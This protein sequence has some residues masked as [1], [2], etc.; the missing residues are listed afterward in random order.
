MLNKRSTKR[1]PTSDRATLQPVERTPSSSPSPLDLALSNAPLPL[2][3]LPGFTLFP[4]T[5]VP[6]HVFEPRYRKLVADLLSGNQLLALPQLKP[7]YE[8]TYYGRPELFPICGAAR[9]VEHAELADGRY[10]ILVQ[11]VARVRLVEE[12]SSSSLY[13]VARVVS[14]P[15]QSTASPLVVNAL[16]DELQSLCSR[17]ERDLPAFA[18]IQ[19]IFREGP[20]PGAIADRVGSALIADPSER[21]ILLDQLDPAARLE[22]LIAHLHDLFNAL[23]RGKPERELN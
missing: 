22:R 14:L 17:L 19:S 21:Q 4:G 6:L 12:V 8:P 5:R 20:S 16:R 9:I 10:N 7:G 3:P 18:T 15:D 13:R 23:S 11:G 2:F 1:L